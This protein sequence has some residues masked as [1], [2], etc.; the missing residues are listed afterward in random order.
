ML[1]LSAFLVDEKNKV[2]EFY[3]SASK[4]EIY[5]DENWIRNVASL[6]EEF[7]EDVLEKIFLIYGDIC[8]IRSGLKSNNKSD[9]QISRLV[10]LISQFFNGVYEGEPE[11]RK[12]YIDILDFLKTKG[13]IKED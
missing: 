4:I 3:D 7:D 13:N 8:S 10:S 2:D 9:Y 12:K 6:Y 1:V 11:L 5:I